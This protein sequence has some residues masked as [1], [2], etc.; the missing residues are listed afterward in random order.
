MNYQDIDANRYICIQCINLSGGVDQKGKVP[1]KTLKIIER[2]IKR[3]NPK[4]KIP[5]G[6]WEDFKKTFS[7]GEKK[8]WH[9][10]IDWYEETASICL[11]FVVRGVYLSLKGEGFKKY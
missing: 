7:A 5:A 1:K 4:S 2:S 10:G 8:S 6:T 11:S 3:A 9:T